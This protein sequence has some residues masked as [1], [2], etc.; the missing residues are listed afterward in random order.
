MNERRVAITGMGAV[1]PLGESVECLI[2]GIEAGKCSTRRMPGWEQYNGLRS[3]VAA[4][5]E[6]KNE[7]L[8]PRKDRRSMSPMSIFA[9]QAANQALEDAGVALE[10]AQPGRVGCVIGSTVGS[11]IGFERI[12]QLMGPGGDLAKLTS[13]QFF[14]CISHTAAMNVAQFLGP[15][16]TVMAPAAACASSLQAVGAGYDLVRTG[17]QDLV[18][19]GGTE[20][21]HPVVTGS[22]DVLYA[23]SIAHNDS[24][25][26]TPRPFDK[27]RDGLVCGEGSGILLLEDYDR[28]AARGATIHAEV[29]GY[30]TC[31]SGEHISQS[32][33]RA[34]VECMTHALRKAGIAPNEVDHVNAHATAT[35]H[36]DVEE[37][38]AIRE[39]FGDTA[40][41]TSLKGYF[42]HTLG[43][44]GTIELIP[45]LVMMKRGILYPT[46]NLETVDP[47]CAGIRHVTEKMEA[48][49]KTVLKNGFAFGGINA[50]LVCRR[51]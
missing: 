19:C 22:F 39:L 18:L 46:L 33:R 25:E 31:G 16:G 3:L 24:P 29:V 8:I 12:F 44:A 45:S 36:G 43:A 34:M 4:P 14:Q 27:D 13:M 49:V 26:Q 10:D 51:V 7:K 17:Q 48:D 42:G 15:T 20:E 21:L 50:T 11:S 40:P 2:A 28:A 6:L 30:H 41:V 38:S 37:A 9:V 32:S 1:S 5:V 35:V 47:D 23:A